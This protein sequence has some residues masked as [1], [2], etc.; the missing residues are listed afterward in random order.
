M[1]QFWDIKID[2]NA[3]NSVLNNISKSVIKRQK[4]I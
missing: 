4:G 2:K 3:V 1:K